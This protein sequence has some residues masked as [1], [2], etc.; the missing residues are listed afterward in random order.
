[1]EE[2]KSS[3]GVAN[4]V[5]D[6]TK[7]ADVFENVLKVSGIL[8]VAG[9]ISLRA[10]L[11]LLGIDWDTSLG[12]E[13]YLTES[14]LLI[15]A[16]MKALV[17][18][19]P[20]IGWSYVIRLVFAVILLRALYFLILKLAIVNKVIQRISGHRKWWSAVKMIVPLSLIVYPLSWLPLFKRNIDFVL[21]APFNGHLWGVD[22]SAAHIYF[23]RIVLICA[24]G[25]VLYVKWGASDEDWTVRGAWYAFLVVL[26]L[27]FYYLPAFY[28]TN[29]REATYPLAAIKMKGKQP[30]CGLLVLQSDK[31]IILWSVSHGTGT[32]AAI[33]DSEIQSIALGQKLDIR[34]VVQ[35]AMTNMSFT[36]DCKEIS[37]SLSVAEVK[38]S[39]H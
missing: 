8:A 21:T 4:P 15:E 22:Y 13:K 34:K 29:L 28:G 31:S 38:K 26:F 2:I 1:V 24:V 17:D 33:S 39:I 35:N 23:A 20:T 12:T 37:E 18:K 32:V 30:V 19:I 25:F 3:D 36:L 27:M 11:S 7:V 16:S 6:K 14:Y 10:H 5:S 9:F